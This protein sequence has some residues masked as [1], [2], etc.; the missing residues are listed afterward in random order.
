MQGWVKRKVKQNDTWVRRWLEVDRHLLYSYQACPA[1]TA[2]A[3][4]INMLDLR[5][6][7]E[8]RLV[9][10]DA[11]LF[12]IVPLSADNSHPGYL[13]WVDTPQMAQDWVTG[14]N[15]V[16][17]R[18]LEQSPLEEETA[19]LKQ[20]LTPVIEDPTPAFFQVFLEAVRESWSSEKTLEKLAPSI[21]DSHELCL[22]FSAASSAHKHGDITNEEKRKMIGDVLSRADASAL[23]LVLGKA[24]RDGIVDRDEADRLRNNPD[25]SEERSK[26]LVARITSLE[27]TEELAG[28]ARSL[29]RCT[30][31]FKDGAAPLEYAGRVDDELATLKA[32]CHLE[33]RAAAGLLSSVVGAL[34]FG[35]EIGIV[36]AEKG[37]LGVDLS[38][39]V[40]FSD[41]RHLIDAVKIDDEVGPRLEYAWFAAPLRWI[42]ENR[43]IDVKY[44]PA[45]AFLKTIAVANDDKPAEQEPDD[46]DE[47]ASIAHLEETPP[48]PPA[49]VG[50]KLVPAVS[51]SVDS[52]VF[53]FSSAEAAFEALKRELSCEE[54]VELEPDE[55]FVMAF[56]NCFSEV[57]F[58]L[59]GDEPPL[60]E[61]LLQQMAEG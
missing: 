47:A 7:K 40:D 13:M 60:L 29:A 54:A 49:A 3:R 12:C 37:V 2:Q 59:L 1:E 30:R 8:I 51:S 25:A 36:D 50:E 43:K 5:K 53:N 22:F 27:L 56:E 11:T 48:P 28:H 41:T 61:K 55:D 18:G 14:L 57:D 10:G 32:A 39:V 20:P 33:R 19:V 17:E 15:K 16:R 6:T 44:L 58:D 52:P 31:A 4:V 23:K 46:E 9:E 34:T 26:S 38:A 35:V 45:C 42:V 24:E 21:T